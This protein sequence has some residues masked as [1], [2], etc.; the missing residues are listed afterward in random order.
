MT[1]RPKHLVI[2]FIFDF[3]CMPLAT[4]QVNLSLGENSIVIACNRLKASLESL[5]KR[6]FTI[7]GVNDRI[8][9]TTSLI[10]TIELQLGR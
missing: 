3:D 1:G 5:F 9:A 4:W 6:Q 10:G 8:D 2:P 7:H